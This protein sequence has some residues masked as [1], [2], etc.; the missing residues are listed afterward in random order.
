MG[1]TQSVF[2]ENVIKVMEK[3]EE[4]KSLNKND[5]CLTIYLKMVEPNC[6]DIY[7][8]YLEKIKKNNN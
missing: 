6:F 4:I 5:T 7:K 1:A 3:Q 8:E 2:D